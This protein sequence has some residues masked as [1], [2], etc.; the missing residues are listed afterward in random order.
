MRLRVRFR[1]DATVQLGQQTTL[2]RKML[3]NLIKMSITLLIRYT[4]HA[5]LYDMEIVIMR[6]DKNNAKNNIRECN[7]SV[8]MDHPMSCHP[9]M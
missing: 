4:H 5:T 1:S 2:I 9:V 7:V 8:F 6:K 3:F